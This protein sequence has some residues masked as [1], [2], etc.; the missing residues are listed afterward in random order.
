MYSKTK[1]HWLL[2]LMTLTALISCT[3]MFTATAYAAKES[4]TAVTSTKNGQ[5][6]N[7]ESLEGLPFGTIKNRTY[8]IEPIEILNTGKQSGDGYEYI[9]KIHHTWV[10]SQFNNVM[11]NRKDR[12]RIQ[13]FSPNS[14]YKG[15]TLTSTYKDP[16]ILVTKKTNTFNQ[17]G[18]GYSLYTAKL[19]K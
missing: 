19:I 5:F 17:N 1:S 7:M 12:A 4:K 11:N 3:F 18:T 10:V 8:L 6:L 9:A 2:K 13:L 14:L 16:T 15:M